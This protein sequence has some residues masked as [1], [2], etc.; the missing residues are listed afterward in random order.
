MFDFIPLIY[1]AAIAIFIGFVGLIWS[2]DRFVAG[3]AAF[4]LNFGVAPIVIGLTVVSFG[5]SAPEV[6]VSLNASLAGAGDI[7]VGN[8]LGSNIAN[9]A[10]VLA[11]TALVAK[12]P[13]QNHILRDE[14]P[15][16]G[17]IT[18]LAGYFLY[19]ATITKTEGWI[20]LLLLAPTLFI[21]VWQKRGALSEKEAQEEQEDIIPM[22]NIK[23]GIWFLIGLVLL[24]ASSKILVWGAQTTAEH[25]HVSP[26]IIGLTV[27]AIGTSLPELA[28]SI[29]SAL[30]GHHDIALGNIIGS[31]IF[32]LLAVM[33]L[34]GIIQPSLYAK[35]VFARDYMTMAGI[36]ALLAVVITLALWRPAA[37]K[38]IGRPT[39]VVLLFV[40][41]AYIFVLAKASL[42]A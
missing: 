17:F 36:T 24:I 12:I 22:S 15:I 4:A 35:E 1:L 37:N 5:T 32:N 7:A 27:L 9:V 20:L 21:M 19:D 28:A 10:L 14:L 38:K 41:G 8:A 23:A 6:L 3:A 11:C 40:Y 29:V 30:K 25:F 31:N 26:L 13:V 16:L 39:G 33:S 18:L 34:P 2:A 42:N